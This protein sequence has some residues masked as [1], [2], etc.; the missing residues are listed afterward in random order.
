MRK[1]AALLSLLFALPLFADEL[2][3]RNAQVTRVRASAD[4]LSQITAAH[5][6]VG[7]LLPLVEPRQIQCNGDSSWWDDSDKTEAIAMLYRVDNGVID[8]IRIAGP[9]CSFNADGEAVTWIENVTERDA[10]DVLIS[11]AKRNKSSRTRSKALFW[12]G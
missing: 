12:L 3:V 4:L 9:E 10:I 2:N 8:S 7:Y 5:G 1:T 6:W 11:V